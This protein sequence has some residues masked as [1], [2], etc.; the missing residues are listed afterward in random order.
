MD[1]WLL[2]LHVHWELH[3]IFL[4][5]NSSIFLSPRGTH[6]LLQMEKPALIP[7]DFKSSSDTWYHLWSC[8]SQR[9]VI[10]GRTLASPLLL[11]KAQKKPKYV[12]FED[13]NPKRK[14]NKRKKTKNPPNPLVIL[15][16]TCLMI[17]KSAS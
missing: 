5:T 7:C 10:T 14:K 15:L 3:R 12:H 16:P 2:F 11:Q 8:R 6:C 1:L 17:C 4:H 9:Q 13:L